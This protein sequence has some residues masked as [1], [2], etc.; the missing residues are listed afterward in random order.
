MRRSPSSVAAK[1][2][3]F[4]KGAEAEK[5]H[6]R[7]SPSSR[8]A[9]TPVAKAPDPDAPDPDA[10][11]AKAPDPDVPVA[12]ASTEIPVAEG[13]LHLTSPSDSELRR[14]MRRSPSSVAAK[15]S[16]FNKGAEAEKLHLRRSPSSRAADTPVAKAPDP[17]APDPDAPVAKAPDPDVPVASASTEI[18]V[19]EGQ[20]HLTSPSDS[21]LRR[22]MRRSPSSVAAKESAFN[23]GAEGASSDASNKKVVK[24]DKKNGPSYPPGLLP[25]ANDNR[26]SLLAKRVKRQQK[27]NAP[28]VKEDSVKGHSV[29]G[30]SVKGDSVKGDSVEGDSVEGDSVEGDS[31]Q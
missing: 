30:D 17:D 24:N 5:L 27:K 21:E 31:K 23:K 15:E 19:A 10:P 22:S 16:A 20:L 18:P 2:S 4:N 11:V 8:A 7:R 9:D 1:E 3:A 28:L 12:S 6:L 26:P 25:N 13:Q 29:E 14:S